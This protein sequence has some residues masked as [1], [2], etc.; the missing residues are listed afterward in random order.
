MATERDALD[1]YRDKRDFDRTP[2]PAGRRRKARPKGAPR[3]VIQQHDATRLHWDLR[4]ERDGVLASWAL[5][6]GVPW[7]PDDNHLAVHT[8][9]HPIE[10]LSF[11]G[12][13]PEGEYGAGNMFVWDTGWYEVDKWEP[14]KV[15]ITL[16]GERARGKY[17]LF[18]T[19]GRDWMIH[20]MDPPE[21]ASRSAVPTYLRPM[22]A[23]TGRLPSDEENWAF[24][25]RWSGLRSLLLGF[26]GAVDLADAD[27]ND[28][29]RHFPE[30]RRI[31]RAL[32]SV[33]AVIDSVIVPGT[34]DRESIDRRL[35]AASDSTIRRLSRDQPVAAVLFDVLW[36]EGHSV[37]DRPWTER[38]SLLESIALDGPAWRTPSAHLGDGA[39]LV[40]AGRDQG[41]PG[42]IAK[43]LD[44]TY[45][46]GKAS[47]DWVDIGL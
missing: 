32:G 43:R 19:R 31:S 14:A 23:R 44:S 35:A 15:V 4:L 21:D 37:L 16:S 33:E 18:Q 2:E 17:A 36:L 22:R 46:P 6:R 42:I 40:A 13:I 30:V 45:Q 11:E 28:I 29:S 3:F 27:G 9:D 34:G 12:D 24:E 20:R 26:T 39:A 8:E 38:R 10:Y 5:P 47:R 7:H 41:V 1:D 25:V